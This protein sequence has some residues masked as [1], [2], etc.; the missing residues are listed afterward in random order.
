MDIKTLRFVITLG[1]ASF[2]AAGDNQYDVQ[3]LR[4]IA[5][6]DNAGGVQMSSLR[7]R[8]YGVPQ[9]VMNM[10]TTLQ[11]RPAGIRPNTVQVYA[12]VGD[13]QTLVFAGNIINAW[14]NYQGM[15]DVFLE[16]QAM[17]AYF[18]QTQAAKP[19][20]YKGAIDAAV[21]FQQIAN[22]MGYTFENNGVSVMLSD[23]Y[24][25]STNLEQ[26]RTLARM[27]NVDLYI[28]GHVLAITP[29]NQPRNVPVPEINPTTGLIGY[30]TFDGVGVNLRVLFNP[31]IIFGGQIH[32]SSSVIPANGTWQVVSL[33]HHLESEKPDGLWMSYVRGLPHDLAIAAK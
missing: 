4:S 1:T 18:A 22:D 29:K 7:A 31:S 14:G 28:D 27:A 24:L 9:D 11:Y 33:A 12:I 13:T 17:A 26:A 5:I 6:I 32:V 15:P 10:A 21:I 20:S 30:P 8:I 19:R 3:G 23:V 2:D 25:A 16:I